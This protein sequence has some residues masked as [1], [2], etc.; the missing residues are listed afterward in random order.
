MMLHMSI[1]LQKLRNKLEKVE[2]ELEKVRG[3]SPLTHGWQTQRYAKSSRKW[4]M[5]AEEKRKLV[6]EIEEEHLTYFDGIWNKVD[7]IHSLPNYYECVLVELANGEKHEAWL[8]SDGESYIW[9]KF[10]TN[11][12]LEDVQFFMRYIKQTK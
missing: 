2:K 1:L 7:N 9:T 3:C 8:A 5:L 4:D 6:M 11:K 12:T 10:G